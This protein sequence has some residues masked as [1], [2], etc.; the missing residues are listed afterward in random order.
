MTQLPHSHYGSTAPPIRLAGAMLPLC[1]WGTSHWAEDGRQC[2]GDK[3]KR[4]PQSCD[5]RF[6][7][8]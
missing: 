5:D 7:N 3:K 4:S 1:Y 2:S 8:Y 6:Q